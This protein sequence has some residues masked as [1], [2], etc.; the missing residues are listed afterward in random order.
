MVGAVSRFPPESEG[1]R[2]G[3]ARLRGRHGY[4]LLGAWD[5]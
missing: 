3:T 5:S 1:E 4:L 2:L